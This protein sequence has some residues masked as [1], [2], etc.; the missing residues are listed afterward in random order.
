M[1]TNRKPPTKEPSIVNTATTKKK[2]GDVLICVKSASPGYTEGKEYTVF[3]N[4]HGFTCLMADD[5]LEDIIS[6]LVS[7]FTLKGKNDE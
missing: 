2:D 1:N 5:G 6:M 3:T 4:K 7:S